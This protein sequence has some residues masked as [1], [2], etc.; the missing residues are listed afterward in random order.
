ML[1]Y[2][3]AYKFQPDGVHGEVLDFPGVLTCGQGIEEARHLLAGA[4][5]D[6]AETN[7]LLGEPLPTPN[8]ELNDAD[9]YI[10][11]PIHLILNA[12]TNFTVLP[13]LVYE[14]A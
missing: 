6:M 12:S 8:P 9:A 1:T 2:R 4:L 3:S 10:V 5:V 11:D 7:L 14:A 13:D